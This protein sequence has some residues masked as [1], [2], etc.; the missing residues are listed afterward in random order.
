MSTLKAKIE[1]LLLE[2]PLE[3]VCSASIFYLTMDGDKVG[4]YDTIRTLANNAVTSALPKIKDKN[5]KSQVL[6]IL[7]QA[8]NITQEDLDYTK[9]EIDQN[10]RTLRSRLNSPITDMTDADEPREK[11]KCK[12]P[13]LVSLKCNE[14]ANNF[15]KISILDEFK[16]IRHNGLWKERESDLGKITEQILSTLGNVWNNPAFETSMSR[17]MQSEGT[18][19]TDIIMPLLRATLGDLPN[20]CICLSTAERQSL[21]SKARRNDG[22]GEEKMGK[23]PDIMA[24]E[25]CNGKLVEFL[26]AECSRVSCSATKK[27]EDEIKLWRELLD[28]SSFINSACKPIHNQ[29]G[30]VGIQVADIPLTSDTPWHVEPLLRLLLTLR[31]IIIVNKSLLTQVLEQAI[32]HPPRNVHTSPTVS[33]PRREEPGQKRPRKNSKTRRLTKR[34]SAYF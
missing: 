29:F 19:I 24:L 18:Y 1:S 13:N 4:E 5:R 10:I 27:E 8:L 34:K 12:L 9:E 11:M 2:A 20:S 31:N 22:I 25:K 30:V 23:K 32:S 6:K 33:S 16:D 14:F 17:N 28:G 26:F 15:H 21:A 7:P 3:A